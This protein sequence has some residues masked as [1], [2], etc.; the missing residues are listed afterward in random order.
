MSTGY[1]SLKVRDYNLKFD[2]FVEICV[3]LLEKYHTLDL[4]FWSGYGIHLNV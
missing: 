3:S 4:K 1:K 2:R